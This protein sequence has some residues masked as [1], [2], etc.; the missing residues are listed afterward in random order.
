MSEDMRDDLVALGFPPAKVEIHY[1]GSPT[2]RFRHPQRSYQ[3]DGPLTV[4]CA[5]RLERYKGQQFAEALSRLDQRTGEDFRLVFV[6]AG[7]TRRELERTVASLR[8]T[9]RVTFTGHVPHASPAL[10]SYFRDADIFVHPESRRESRRASRAR[11]LRRWRRAFRWS[12][13]TTAAFPQS[14]NPEA[15]PARYASTTSSS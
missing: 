14:S 10:V 8:W 4:L 13:R 3:R 7:S 6:G 2:A 9:D 5:G 12:R 1:H 15:R 11:S